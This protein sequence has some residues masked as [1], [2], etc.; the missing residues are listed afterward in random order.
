[1]FLKIAKIILISMQTYVFEA[2]DVS[3]TRNR[4]CPP[5][6]F[7]LYP[8]IPSKGDKGMED[9]DNYFVDLLLALHTMYNTDLYIK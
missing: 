7:I 3:I 6:L 1:M 9:K 4:G 5:I 8:F 2:P